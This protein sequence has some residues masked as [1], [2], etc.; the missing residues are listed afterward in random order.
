MGLCWVGVVP[1][2]A[3]E[4]LSVELLVA[5][6]GF[7]W[8]KELFGLDEIIISLHV[9]G[10]GYIARHGGLDPA[11]VVLRWGAPILPGLLLPLQVRIG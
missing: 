10:R 8:I 2:L 9:R 1:F 6:G 4:Q 11:R 5:F 7:H 3:H